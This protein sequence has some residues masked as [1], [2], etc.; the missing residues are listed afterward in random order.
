MVGILFTRLESF[1]K[2]APGLLFF[3]SGRV[4]KQLKAPKIIEDN[5]HDRWFRGIIE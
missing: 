3:Y 4:E 5:E 2:I 1:A